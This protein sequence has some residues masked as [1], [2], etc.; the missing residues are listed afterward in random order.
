MRSRAKTRPLPK[1]PLR[2]FAHLLA[3]GLGFSFVFLLVLNQPLPAL[4]VAL[5]GF[6]LSKDEP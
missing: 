1:S 3:M 6:L 2:W 5:L 4:L